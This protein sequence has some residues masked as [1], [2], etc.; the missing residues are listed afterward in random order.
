MTRALD[1]IDSRN[2]QIGY[3]L[4]FAGMALVG[5]YVAL[6]KPLTATFPVLLLAWLRFA[7]AA[8]AM[9][10]WL[11]PRAGDA[12]LNAEL[13]GTVFVQ[14]LFGNF[15]FSILML[16]GV[17]RTSALAAGVVLSTIPA[18]VALLS[19]LVLRERL[20]SRTWLAVGLAVAG[21]AV[22]GWV[23]S[24]DGGVPGGA[25]SIGNLLLLGAVFCEATYV[26]LGK[27]LTASLSARRISALLNL[28][29][30]VLTTPFGLWQAIGFDFAQVEI[31][32]WSLLVFYA[33]SASMFSTWLWL[34]GLRH[35]PASHS[36]V[37][38]AA[39]P[40][41]A[42]IV[43]VMVLGEQAVAAH[44]IALGCTVAAIVLIASPAARRS[45]RVDSHDPGPNI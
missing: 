32:Q 43:A 35:V 17:A 9:L 40:L 6:S 33:L 13:V 27:R 4:L 42:G 24:A 22:L 8:V 7:I 25:S 16:S 37:F 36:A 12:P 31:G 38:T 20:S 44:A 10:P 28:W 14:S 34:A 3:L 26:V 11:A 23:R 41:T 21:V 1:A 19:W 45:P 39:M 29:G 30:L 15:L 18:A 2:P 5:V